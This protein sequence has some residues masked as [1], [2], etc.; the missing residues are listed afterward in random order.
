MKKLRRIISVVIILCLMFLLCGCDYIDDL[1]K[2]HAKFVDG[3]E[4]IQLEL[5]RRM[6]LFGSMAGE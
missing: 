1:R 5:C 6:Y 2:T 4:E 3:Y